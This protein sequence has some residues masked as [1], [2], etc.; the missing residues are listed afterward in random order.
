VSVA[1]GAAYV[2]IA[3]LG[4]VRRAAAK[5]GRISLADII[6]QSDEWRRFDCKLWTTRRSLRVESR[7][8][9]TGFWSSN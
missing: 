8:V 5:A 9:P 2:R 7:V 6:L 3:V 4:A 1:A